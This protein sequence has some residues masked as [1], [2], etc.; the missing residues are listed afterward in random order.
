MP[1]RKMKI[2]DYK[3]ENSVGG[4]VKKAFCI[5]NDGVKWMIK[6]GREQ[7]IFGELLGYRM[8]QKLGL[9][10]PK[11]EV[12]SLHDSF[13]DSSVDKLEFTGEYVIKQ[14]WLDK[15]I[16]FRDI[17]QKLE[18]LRG[19]D[20]KGLRP[21]YSKLQRYIEKD[22]SKMV[23]FDLII[24]N[25]D[26]RNVNYG[27]EIDGKELVLVDHNSSAPYCK[28]PDKEVKKVKQALE[29]NDSD[30]VWHFIELDNSWIYN[31]VFEL[32]DIKWFRK[33]EPL[34]WLSYGYIQSVKSWC[35]LRLK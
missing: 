19:R 20:R 5:D 13:P 6:D 22:R 24:G 7:L 10:A 34:C 25:A 3:F 17:N 29:N 21:K 35:K 27:T 18:N 12:I 9:R 2:V 26:R 1:N 4:L 33:I 31:T 8:A 11:T 14:E 15:F 32:V 28:R 16:T 23:L 30:L